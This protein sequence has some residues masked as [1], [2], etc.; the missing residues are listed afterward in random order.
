MAGYVKRA[1]KRVCGS[2]LDG[3]GLTLAGVSAAAPGQSKD[4]GGQGGRCD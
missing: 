2:R 1:A 4:P 3:A